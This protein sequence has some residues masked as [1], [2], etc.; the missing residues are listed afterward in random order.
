LDNFLKFVAVAVTFQIGIWGAVVGSV[1]GVVHDPDHRP[2]QGAEVTVKSATSDLVQTLT[3]DSEGSFEAA[4][5]APGKYVLTVRREGF[6]P[7]IKEAV[8]GSRSAPILHFQLAIGNRSDAVTVSENAMAVNPEQMTPA[9]IVSRNEIALTPGADLSNSMTAITNFVPGAWITHDQLH[10]RGGHQV[11]WAIDG[12]PIPNTNIASNIGPQI[13]PKDIDYLE[14]ER[15]GYSSVY[16]DRTYGLFNVVPRTGFERN[17]ELE[18]NTTIGT[19]HQ[20]NDQINIGGHTEKLGYFASVNGNRS[21]YGLETPGPEVF[22]DRVWGLGGMGSL[23]YNRDANNQFRFVTSMRLD[24]YQIPSDRAGFRDVELE[25]DALA[26]FSWVHIFHP[27]LLFTVSP[28][29]HYNRAN[30]DSDPNEAPVAATQHRESL[31]AGAQISLNEVTKK[32]NASVGLY[33]FGQRDDEL[34]G[35]IANDGS[36][37]AVS[38]DRKSTGHMEALFLEDQYK[39]LPWLTLTLGARLTHFSGA[40]SENAA[41]PRLGGAIRVPRLNWVLRAFWGRYYQAPPLSTVSGPLLNFAVTQGLGFIPLHGER[42]QEH[43]F[44]LTIPLRGWSLDL[45]NYHQRANNYFDHNAIGNSNVFFPLTI[46]GARLYG[47]EA[48][49][50]SPKIAHRGEVYFTYSY[51]HAE[52]QGAV[53][54]GLTDFSPPSSG[55]FLLDHDQRRTLHTGFNLSLPWHAYASGSLYYGSGFTDGSS[56]LPA[57]LE[58]HNTGDFSFGKS[59][60]EKLTVSVTAMNVTNRRFLLDNSQTFGGTHYAEPRQIY[61]QVK[62]RFRL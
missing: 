11:T 51:A 49:V 20:S 12:V 58:G 36:G 9:T 35:L 21:D 1:R 10:V 33:G 56:D 46:S 31:Y 32:H 30:Y 52:G 38:E 17:N 24:D 47:W 48:T 61:L 59:V 57:H 53:S 22:H 29:Y 34:V 26:S 15:G 43:Q 40:I 3:T 44:G 25:R 42:D 62:Y 41:D 50:R 16:G 13:D 8:I 4:A 60:S 14:A 45:N 18:L 27:G 55:Y 6:S 23:I 2:I 19:F 5:L 54:G 39:V 37:V 7:S 28:F